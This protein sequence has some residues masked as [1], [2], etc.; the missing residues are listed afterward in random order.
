MRPL[1]IAGGAGGRNPANSGG[2]VGRARVGNGLQVPGARF[3]GFVGEE[4]LPARAH[5]GTAGRQPLGALLR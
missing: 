2:G 4:G 5:S 1:A 3:P